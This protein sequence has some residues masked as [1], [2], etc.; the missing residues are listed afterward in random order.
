M[1]TTQTS[2]YLAW[3][4]GCTI[5]QVRSTATDNI[6]GKSV[7]LGSQTYISEGASLG[8]GGFQIRGG[9]RAIGNTLMEDNGSYDWHGH[10]TDDPDYIRE[11]LL[12]ESTATIT[13]IPA[14]AEVVLAYLYWS[15]WWENDYAD[16]EVSFQVDS[17][18]VTAVTASKYSILEA[19]NN[20]SYASF[21]DVTPLVSG[22]SA[23]SD[24]II[25]VGGVSGLTEEHWSYAGWS[26]IIFYSSPSELAHQF[27]LYDQFLYADSSYDDHTFVIEG[28]EAPEDAEAFLTCFV[29]EGD[30]WLNGDY[31]QF[32]GY[33]LS[34]A[35]N[36]A[37]DVWNGKS[38]GLGGQIIDGVDIDSFNVSSPIIDPGDT[39]AQ[40]H[41]HTNTDAWNLVYIILAFRSE[42][43]GL[44]PNATGIVS[45]TYGG[46]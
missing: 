13:A 45:Y 40:V 20:Y 10:W 44:T 26:L 25:T 41:L 5:F 23:G 1:R 15:A 8:E 2:L 32:N 39:S 22:I 37:N 30:D 43:G 7:T 3:E 12:S 14:D 24:H 18:N 46:P 34:D 6:T 19:A 42:Y 27:F 17:G 31:I 4:T 9:Y 38:S 35:V 11:T 28:F 21:A 36:P 29:G 16:T 33:Q